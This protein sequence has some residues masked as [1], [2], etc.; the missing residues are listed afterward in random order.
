MNGTPWWNNQAD[1]L[2]YLGSAAY[3]YK[4]DMPDGTSITLKSGTKG[5]AASCFEG[6]TGLKSVTFPSTLNIICE[7]A[8]NGCTGLKSVTVPNSVTTM[9]SYTF[10]Y[11]I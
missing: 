10:A 4:G 5:I 8:F 9:Y 11:C 6:C 7:Y 3:K 2:V 1:G